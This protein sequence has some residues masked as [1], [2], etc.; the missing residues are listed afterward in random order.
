MNRRSLLLGA[1]ALLAAPSIVRVASLMPVSVKPAYAGVRE[2]FAWDPVSNIAAVRYDV[3]LDGKQYGLD[4]RLSLDGP[5]NV[6]PGKRADIEML[7]S[8]VERMTGR[9]VRPSEFI[10]PAIP[11]DYRPPPLQIP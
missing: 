11:P 6:N 7:I 8:A 1:G 4:R 10:Q 3:I 2:L 5:V 9:S